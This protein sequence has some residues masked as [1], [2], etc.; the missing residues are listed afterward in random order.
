M[1]I[2]LYYIAPW[3]QLFAIGGGQFS[4]TDPGGA[5]P[6]NGSRV[7]IHGT[8]R[9]DITGHY[10][11]TIKPVSARG[12]AKNT[13]MSYVEA[14][15]ID[16]LGLHAAIQADSEIALAP[17]TPGNLDD[18]FGTL[19]AQQQALVG[20]ALESVFM[21]SQ[22]ITTARTFRDIMSYVL[23][24]LFGAQQLGS[25]YPDGPLNSRWNSLNGARQAAIQAFL[26]SFNLPAVGGNPQIRDVINRIAQADYGDNNPRMGR[27]RFDAWLP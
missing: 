13:C 22:W 20:N 2:A 27:V 8:W 25:D 12:Q 10:S 26:S 6:V 11:E 24:V 18:A 1:T 9:R 21:D 14:P 3:L 16:P 4:L 5:R 19:T 23:H 17:W 7:L 15:D